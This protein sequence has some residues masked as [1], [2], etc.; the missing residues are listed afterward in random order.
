MFFLAIGSCLLSH[1]VHALTVALDIGHSLDHPGATSARGMPEFQFNQALANTVKPVL[2][3]LGF[4][5]LM[6]G[7]HGD[8]TDLRIRTRLAKSADFFL[9]L[10]HDSVQPQYL[11]GWIHNGVQHAYSDL[12]SGFSVFV[13]RANPQPKI[14]LLCAS[15]IGQS[16]RHRGFKTTDHHAKAVSGENHQFA[17]R[18]NG[19]YYFDGLLVLKTASQPA[20]LLESGIIVNRA[21]ELKLQDAATR[22]SIAESVGDALD[23]CLYPIRQRVENRKIIR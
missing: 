20:V 8:M 14:S 6:I 15:K 22:N 18:L 9:S 1:T 3:R 23:N 2:E 16:L 5:V 13:S 10:H 11:T 17:D 4:A 21:D 12:F 7:D 19:V